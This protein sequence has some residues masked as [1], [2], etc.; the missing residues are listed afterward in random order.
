MRAQPHT[1]AAPSTVRFSEI[2]PDIVQEVQ[3]VQAQA[4]TAAPGGMTPATA[5][6]VR[7]SEP[8]PDI[9][10]DVQ[11]VAVANALSAAPRSALAETLAQMR[12]RGVSE[13]EIASFM[14]QI[15][16]T[17]TSAFGGPAPNGVPFAFPRAQVLTPT[18]SQLL[19][20][21][22]ETQVGT[23]NPPLGAL[24][25][26]LLGA[27]PALADRFQVT[28]GIGPSVSGGFGAGA[29]LG[30]GVM[31]ASAGRV[32]VYGSLSGALG[33]IASISATVQVTIV[34]G[35]PENFS[36][37]ALAVTVGG[38]GIVGSASALLAAQSPHGF[39][40][41]SFEM[42]VGAGLSPIEAYA[43]YQYTAGSLGMA[44]VRQRF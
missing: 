4:L 30:A 25:V 35:G 13:N 3:V 38:E 9:A 32:G 23:V 27:L 42:G 22:I 36:G 8:P 43:Q 20:A 17:Y 28:V 1:A 10:Q 40:G 18:Q 26:P 15:G 37:H 7:F 29:S 19:L 31:F 34:R 5:T 14:Q 33:V 24:M 11:V 2:P 6:P 16:L 12:A 44:S 39:I 41:V 21:A